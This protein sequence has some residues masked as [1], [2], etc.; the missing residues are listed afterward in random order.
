MAAR[1]ALSSGRPGDARTFVDRRRRPAGSGAGVAGRPLAG[2]SNHA[3]RR[4]RYRLAHQ[5][6]VRALP[7]RLGLLLLLVSACGE[8]LR[9]AGMILVLRVF[10]VVRPPR[11]SCPPACS[12]QS[13][14]FRAKN[15]AAQLPSHRTSPRRRFD[16]RRARSRSPGVLTSSRG[17][18]APHRPTT[19]T[20]IVLPIE[21]RSTH[22]RPRRDSSVDR[23]ADSRAQGARASTPREPAL[24]RV[25]PFDVRAAIPRRTRTTLLELLRERGPYGVGNG[26]PVSGANPSRISSSIR[27]TIRE[28]SG[29]SASAIVYSVQPAI[30]ASLKGLSSLAYSRPRGRAEV[31]HAAPARRHPRRGTRRSARCCGCCRRP[32]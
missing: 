2:T 3:A 28:V 31:R 20:S 15:R 21:M 23:L 16:R 30:S 14:T 10:L 24:A 32:R 19:R 11:R 12:G 25:D 5:R 9:R 8:V 17:A 22:V 26:V 1:V 13:A 7:L 6:L 27:T 18:G 29:L 4:G